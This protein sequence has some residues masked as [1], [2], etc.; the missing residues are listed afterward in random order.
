LFLPSLLPGGDAVLFEL[1]TAACATRDLAVLDI[2]SGAVDVLVPGATRG[3]YVN[4]GHL[5]YATDEGAVYG[6]SFDPT[7]REITGA[8]VPLLEG[9]RTAGGVNRGSRLSLS[10]S[11]AMIY[12]PGNVTAG[13]EVLEV[14]RS[15]GETVVISEAQQYEHPRWSPG[16]DRIAVGLAAGG[17]PQIWVYDI[18][19]GT[20]SQLTFEGAN[21]RPTWSPD[22]TRVA[23]FSTRGDTSDLYWQPADGSGPPERVLDGEDVQNSGTTF[24]TRDGSWIVF[25]GRGDAGSNIENIYAVGT[26][27]D[28]TRQTA[29]ATGAEEETGAVSPNGEW[30]AYGSDESGEWQVYVRAFLAPGGRW[31]VST[32]GAGTPLWTSDTEVVYVDYPTRSL[33]AARLE[34]GATV[35]VVERTTL[36]SFRPYRYSESSPM[37]DVSRDGQRFLVLRNAEGAVGDEDPIVVLNWFE[38]IKRRIA[39]QGGR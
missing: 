7:R 31:L 13:W 30:I 14:D 18:Q 35:R 21:I 11:G 37:Y 15:G 29:V 19:S 9:V 22:G 23:Y 25:D 32:G 34:F 26:D 27:T 5:V 1:C 16:G 24:W 28:R 10:V 3:W 4:T 2:Q 39:E 17:P 8:P 20:L 12:Q 36:F 33:M 6:V 38:E